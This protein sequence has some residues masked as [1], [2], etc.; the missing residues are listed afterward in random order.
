M[1]AYRCHS[2][3]RSPWR[4]MGG[5]TLVEMMVA[6]GISVFLGAGFIQMFVANNQTYNLSE[7]IG[8]IQE[9]SRYTL[10]KLKREIQMAGFTGCG[11]TLM[12]YQEGEEITPIATS[13][14]NT[15]VVQYA[16]GDLFD[17]QT[18]VQASQTSPIQ[19]GNNVTKN[20]NATT[21]DFA[22]GQQ[23]LLGDC[24]YAYIVT[25]ATITAI[26][27]GV[28][29]SIRSGSIDQMIFA[30]NPDTGEKHGWTRGYHQNTYQVQDT[31]RTSSTGGA[32]NGLYRTTNVLNATTQEMVEGIDAL[33]L[34]YKVI[35]D[36]GDEDKEGDTSDD[37]VRYVTEVGPSTLAHV[38]D[39][40]VGVLI[41]S[42]GEITDAYG[43][44]GY[45][46]L[47]DTITVPSD[48][49]VRKTSGAFVNIR[50]N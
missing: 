45:S 19:I 10:D 37:L 31:G 20:R 28:E 21:G 30:E 1:P 27:G 13:A 6:V 41:S 25:I 40:E 43:A 9:N 39:I 15:L 49:R 11:G 36:Y 38:R 17:L 16:D 44:T 8:R 42:S 2:K 23:L 29:L 7:S 34:R 32:I 18:D 12:T 35:V 24:Q 48:R 5:L 47:G 4:T 33:R 3:M 46:L 14:V 50:N 26:T 22:F